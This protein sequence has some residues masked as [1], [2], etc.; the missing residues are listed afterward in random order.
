MN[1]GRPGGRSE[2]CGM[3]AF[4]QGGPS[5]FSPSVRITGRAF[6]TSACQ[7]LAHPPK[8][9]L[10]TPGGPA[11]RYNVNRNMPNPSASTPTMST[12]S[13]NSGICSAAKGLLGN[14]TELL[15]DGAKRNPR[16]PGGAR[17]RRRRI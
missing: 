16:S 14:R 12:A 11:R 3:H 4:S 7:H 2:A 17:S 9:F 1:E 15:C 8:R 13:G 10:T 6:R 5:P